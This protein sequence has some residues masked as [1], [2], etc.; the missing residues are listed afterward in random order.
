MG[1]GKDEQLDS[2]LETEESASQALKQHIA[3]QGAQY[4]S[5]LAEKA[6]GFLVL[7]RVPDRVGRTSQLKR[8]F[9]AIAGTAGTYGFDEVHNLANEAAH[10]LQSLEKGQEH[11]YTRESWGRLRIAA[12]KLSEAIHKAANHCVLPELHEKVPSVL[13]N[14]NRPRFLIVDQDPLGL[15]TFEKL[16]AELLLDSISASNAKEALQIATNND[17]DGVFLDIELEQ[18]DEGFRLARALRRSSNSSTVPVAVV[19]AVGDLRSRI[20]AAHAGASLYLTKPVTKQQ[21]QDATILLSSHRRESGQMALLV[22][23]DHAFANYVETVLRSAD[24]TVQHTDKAGAIL[25]M[26]QQ[27]RPDIVLLDVDLPDVNGL[28]VCSALRAMPEFRDLP[29]LFLSADAS[30]ETRLACFEAGG[31]DYIQKPVLDQ[32]LIARTRIRLER[33]RM[34]RDHHERDALTGLLNR[35]SFI[36]Q[37]ASKLNEIH[38]AARTFSVGLCDVD[39]FKQVNDLRG[40]LVGDQVLANFGKILQEAFRPADLKCRWG[41]EEFLVAFAEQEADAAK[42]I[43]ERALEELKQTVFTDEEGR[44]FRVT[45]SAGIATIPDD[46]DSLDHLVRVADRRLYL[47]KERGRDQIVHKG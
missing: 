39:H 29:V 36:N 14:R 1:T 17:L 7:P 43:L 46:G 15:R 18:P 24:L 26:V 23:D 42:A 34:T 41:G 13:R 8:R 12:E 6:D 3:H 45:C 21:F 20:E 9:H 40:H 31:D 44:E 47:A 19:T 33:A 35:R 38:R 27:D 30:V 11:H 28:E 16:C 37:A 2:S 22:E 5:S 4:I 32:E 25:E 10:A